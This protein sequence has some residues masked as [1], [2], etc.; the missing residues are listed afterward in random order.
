M[1]WTCGAASA[2]ALWCV[3]DVAHAQELWTVNSD[4]ATTTQPPI[5]RTCNS[6]WADN[7][8]RQLECRNAEIDSN[9][10]CPFVET[11]TRV[12]G[13]PEESE[14]AYHYA[15]QQC[16]GPDGTFH[17]TYDA[18][19]V[20]GPEQYLADESPHRVVQWADF[21]KDAKK[22]A[23]KRLP[24]NAAV[25][26]EKVE[27]CAG[28]LLPVYPGCDGGSF[29]SV[30][31]PDG[32][33][34]AL[35]GV[36]FESEGAAGGTNMVVRRR[37]P[38]G[39]GS[40]AL[41][42]SNLP[43]LPQCLFRENA[44]PGSE[45]GSGFVCESPGPGG[46]R[47]TGADRRQFTS[48]R[49][50]VRANPT[51]A[52]SI[53]TTLLDS[54]LDATYAAVVN[55]D[56]ALD[57]QSVSY[58]NDIAKDVCRS[59]D[60]AYFQLNNSMLEVLDT[61]AALNPRKDIML[62]L[63]RSGS[64]YDG[65]Y[66]WWFPPYGTQGK[67]IGSR[68]IDSAVEAIEQFVAMLEPHPLTR[69]GLFSYSAA[70]NA[71]P[72]LDAPLSPLTEALQNA[73]GGAQL[74][75]DFRSGA[76]A[77]G[78]ALVQALSAIQGRSGGQTSIGLGL[79]NAVDA[80]CPSENG[81]PGVCDSSKAFIVFTDGKENAPPCVGSEDCSGDAFDMKQLGAARV[82]T[83]G[84]GDQGDVNVELL[85]KLALDGRGAFNLGAEVSVVKADDATDPSL[86][87]LEVADDS[88]ELAMK[89]AFSKCAGALM[90]QPA[91]VDPVGV[92]PRAQLAAA[93]ETYSPCGDQ[94]LLFTGGWG[95]GVQRDELHL[96]VNDPA[97]DLVV[98]GRRDDARGSA[99]GTFQVTR[100]TGPQS[101]EWRSQVVRHHNRYVNGFAPTAFVD[102]QGQGVP[103]VRRQ[104][105]RLCPTGCD[106]VLYYEESVAPAS[107]SA[108]LGA[109][110]AESESGLLGSVTTATSADAFNNSLSS[111]LAWD[112][113]VYANTSAGAYNAV[114][115]YD[116]ALTQ[117]LCFS[118][119]AAIV[120]DLRS[121][122]TSMIHQLCSGALALA[123][124]TN[125]TTL[126][127]PT[128]L[129]LDGQVALADP[130]NLG[131]FSRAVAAIDFTELASRIETTLRTLAVDSSEY[132]QLASSPLR[133]DPAGAEG[134]ARTNLAT[135]SRLYRD[136]PARTGPSLLAM[137]L[138]RVDLSTMSARVS[139]LVGT[140]LDS[141]S[142]GMF[143]TPNLEGGAVANASRRE[144]RTRMWYSE[145][146]FS[147]LS[148]I[149]PQSSSSNELTGSGLRLG[150]T[151]PVTSVPA[152]G[153]LDV[154]AIARVEV[155]LE[156]YGGAVQQAGCGT[157]ASF[158]GDTVSARAL[159]VNPGDISTDVRE[160]V[161]NDD[162]VSGDLTAGNDIW[163]TVVEDLGT[164]DGDY[165]VRY[166][167][168]FLV[169]DG[170]GGTCTQRREVVDTI[171][172][173]PGV[174]LASSSV[175]HQRSG[176]ED[177]IRFT[178][179]DEYGNP[180]GCGA[181]PEVTCD[182]ACGCGQV[183]DNRDGSYTATVIGA[184]QNGCNCVQAFGEEFCGGP[185]IVAPNMTVNVCNDGP[186]EVAL[187]VSVPSGTAQGRVV[188]NGKI[189]GA[190]IDASQ[191]VVLLP[192]G[193]SSIQWTARANGE[194]LRVTQNVNVVVGD[195]ESG[196]C[197]PA[198]L[199]V[200]AGDA[201]MN[202]YNLP[203]EASYCVL[204]RGGIDTVVTGP[205]YDVLYGG[206]GSDVLSNL[207]AEGSTYGGDDADAL[208]NSEGG[209]IYGGDGGD[210][211][212]LR[213]DGEVWG[214]A[215][216]D[217]IYLAEGDHFIYPGA[218]RDFVQG[219]PGS[220][221]VTVFHK[222][223]FSWLE[224][225]N[226]GDGYDTL[227]IPVPASQLWMHGVTAIGFEKVIVRT[228]LGHLAECP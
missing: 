70:A 215:G 38:T 132:Q 177:R 56:G 158:S 112:L 168:E 206:A 81:M 50:L 37:D 46:L 209:E 213:G 126:V 41:P 19:R 207:S 137:L 185:K 40:E 226:G 116:N 39:S 89:M 96:L 218:G 119:A 54:Y 120:T 178:P 24:G 142:H 105:Q 30:A 58:C 205:R 109:L 107:R 51:S 102:L 20:F 11:A 202:L 1:K 60:P 66:G 212:D 200:V 172:M 197:C 147:G 131:V 130:A 219:G 145:I 175:T 82:C 43:R 45:C 104:I 113:I 99:Q 187:S 164:I 196:A 84:F 124:D 136:L 193:A 228:D 138:P 69:L 173:K 122:Q 165:T 140:S 88:A 15:W 36:S 184:A 162:G 90:D 225:L 189:V 220:D 182:A 224:T 73:L 144:R 23:E 5:V 68:K 190:P 97:G 87:A 7:P 133:L 85:R 6:P 3:C 79:Q 16:L 169:D 55:A 159:A 61:T 156:S 183:V 9:A 31:T 110:T 125:F 128:G 29:T 64:M 114:A 194:E 74:G 14:L 32:A 181:P 47:F 111:P 98:P 146:R 216:N 2:A 179:R 59:R 155:P 117:R 115:A 174:K 91:A 92:L 123:A 148:E 204:G 76:T 192:T 49:D 139:G 217:T 42:G 188:V 62:V 48:L 108:Y 17:P 127:D 163:S 166:M 134:Q 161:L 103:L 106:R 149:K 52:T 83:I 65:S 75:A 34:V 186:T 154:R 151:V 157:S 101:G 170:Q 8:D 77:T 199:T 195:D 118:S 35:C 129:L 214:N 153:Y 135:S 221:V 191:P 150:F 141:V 78:P 25:V 176:N 86:T 26:E 227:V 22:R 121:S 171:S 93:A 143:G 203:Q 167:A 201:G 94:E 100:V 67:P 57:G 13:H 95:R 211:I 222:C 4:P 210:G 33:E 198:G 28:E 80:A 180:V 63:D 10:S 71:D 208:Y 12:A 53:V 72:A 44:G 18:T 223:E 160:F 27:F 21:R 152:S